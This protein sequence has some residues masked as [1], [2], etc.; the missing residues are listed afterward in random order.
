MW[1]KIIK[2][3]NK[4]FYISNK[5]VHNHHSFNGHKIY[6][7]YVYLPLRKYNF[8]RVNTAHYR[9]LY[10]RKNNLIKCILDSCNFS[11]KITNKLPVLLY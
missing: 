2:K 5:Q 9:A 11:R 6:L 1:E 8:V 10:A 7:I 3:V 4:S